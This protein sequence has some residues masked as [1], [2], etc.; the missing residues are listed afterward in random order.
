MSAH[1][2]NNKLVKTSLRAQ[3]FRNGAVKPDPVKE[4]RR[5]TGALVLRRLNAVLERRA[6]ADFKT[7]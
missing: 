1:L 5:K 7:S 6:R 3:L 4:D 2:L